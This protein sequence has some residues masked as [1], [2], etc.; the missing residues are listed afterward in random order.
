MN[1][2]SPEARHTGLSDGP[3]ARFTLQVGAED[4]GK[5]LDAVLAAHLADLS[6]TRVQALIRSGEVTV[7][8]GKIVEP[9]YRVNE[10][11]T[12]A[13]GLPEPEEAEPKGEDIPLVV[14]YEDDD[15]IVIDKPA[16]LVVHPGAGNWTGTLV[17]ALIR[18]CGDSLSGIGGVRRPGIVHRLDKETS[19]LLVVAKTDAAHKGLSEQFADHGRSGPLERAYA[20][21][22]WGA[23]ATL[24][25]TV[26]ANLA[27]S[28]A[29]RQ[30]ISVVRNGGRHAV[31]H[32]QVLERFG[33]ADQPAVASLLEC[34]LETGRTHQIRVHMAHIGHPLI[35]DQIYG[36]GFRTKAN[37]FPEPIRTHVG[38]FPRQALHAGLLAFA[39]PRTGETLR[40]ESPYPD[41]FQQLLGA[42]RKF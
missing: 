30:K 20:A 31:T 4:A 14:V 6:R 24:R 36:A 19:G 5:R 41:D 3:D 8:G 17:N 7:D 12:L 13:L 33:P 35:G 32:W 38:G 26:D 27:R 29:N 15:L 39:H 2:T 9:K 34:R 22:V 37:R 11:A 25:G 16:G 23:P 10:G 18:H 28:D 21:L 40:F 1:E 42:L